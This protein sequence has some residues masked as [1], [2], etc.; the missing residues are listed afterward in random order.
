MG[1]GEIKLSMNNGEY[2]FL[3][4]IVKFSAYEHNPPSSPKFVILFYNIESTL[5]LRIYHDDIKFYS[6]FIS[7]NLIHPF[8]NSP[9]NKLFKYL[10]QHPELF[11]IIVKYNDAIRFEAEIIFTNNFISKNINT[12]L[13]FL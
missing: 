7:H 13:E 2:E 8:K 9:K 6:I 3:Y 12:F 4:R 11:Q 10:Q 5:D 1:M